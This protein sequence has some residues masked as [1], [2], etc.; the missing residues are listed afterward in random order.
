MTRFMVSFLH[1]DCIRGWS[2]FQVSAAPGDEAQLPSG[3]PMRGGS[4]REIVRRRTTCAGANGRDVG[5]A[6]PQLRENR[7]IGAA[8]VEPDLGICAGV[9]GYRA[10]HGTPMALQL[11]GDAGVD[12]VATAADGG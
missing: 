10:G 1:D 7:R 5:W 9:A 2:P 3:D 12:F 4:I 6:H 8:Q 11:V